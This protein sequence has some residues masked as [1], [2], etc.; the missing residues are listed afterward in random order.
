MRELQVLDDDDGLVD[1]ALAVDQQRE[2]AAASGLSQSPRL[3]VAAT[4]SNR[5]IFSRSMRPFDF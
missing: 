4:G 2:L 5:L 1:V 3:R